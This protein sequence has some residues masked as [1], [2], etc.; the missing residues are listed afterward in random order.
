MKHK[1]VLKKSGKSGEIPHGE[2]LLEFI[3]K[4]FG[5]RFI[6]SLCRGGSCGT[7]RV[8]LI[9]GKVDQ[10]TT[11]ARTAADDAAGRI[12]TC[13]ARALSDIVLDI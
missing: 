12:L 8:K 3:D 6:P 4:E 9:S 1:I 7:C 10:D 13:S 5:P 11:K 2:N